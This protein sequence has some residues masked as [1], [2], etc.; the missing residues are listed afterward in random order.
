M[1]TYNIV[2]TYSAHR[3]SKQ[4]VDGSQ[5]AQRRCI[6]V[7]VGIGKTRV[8]CMLISSATVVPLIAQ[9]EYTSAL[10]GSMK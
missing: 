10:T 4:C 5:R 1:H 7:L 3:D 6:A 8:L 2:H 9:P